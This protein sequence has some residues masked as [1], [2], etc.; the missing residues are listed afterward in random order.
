[1]ASFMKVLI[2][3]PRS[4]N[5]SRAGGAEIY[6]HE[7]L[8]RIK[9]CEFFIISSSDRKSRYQY[10]SYI[11]NIVARSEYLFPICSAKYVKRIRN[12]D[13]IIENISKFPIIWP[14]LLSKLLSKPFI[15]I[16][17]HIHGRTLFRELPFPIA[18]IFYVYETL[19]LKIYSL[20]KPFLIT[21]STSTKRELLRLGFSQHK[22]F[23]VPPGINPKI[24]VSCNT[25][26]AKE[27][28]IVYVGRVKQYKRLDHLIK[29]MVI[30]KQRVP[31]A[32]CVIAGRGDDDVYRKLRSLA[33]RLGL[34]ESVIFEGEVNEERKLELMRKAWVFVNPSM[35]EGF[36]INSLEAQACGTPVIG[37][38]I[39]GLVDCVKSG[40][41]GLLVANGDHKALTEAIIN[42]LLNEGLRLKMSKNA[43]LY[44]L[45]FDWKM[46][47]EK[48][49][50]LLNKVIRDAKV[51]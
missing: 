17:Y 27:P 1:M 9:E 36:S 22:I 10:L 32:Q 30:V 45:S 11:E 41:T 29:S 6:L 23:I 49:L 33:E 39:P 8:G 51:A 24:A 12:F 26:K 21:I 35:K 3:N 31:N 5:C 38:K 14:L 18:L 50:M 25:S 37:Y 20:L 7:I 43:M 15:G 48:F 13:I 16:I 34:K 42:V 4:I 28:F 2:F 19:S 46:S 44:G 40:V 47:A